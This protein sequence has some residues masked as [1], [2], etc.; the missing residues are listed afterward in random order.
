MPSLTQPP[1]ADTPAS[2]SAPSSATPASPE[3]PGS[4]VRRVAVL[5]N[6]NVGKTSLFNRLCG[7]RHKTSNFPGTTQEARIG[8]PRGAGSGGG[9][10]GGVVLVD[11]PGVYSLELDQPESEVCRAVLAGG[12]APVGERAGVPDAVLVVLDAT[13][14]PRGLVLLGEVIRRRLPVL[15]AVNQADLARRRGLK[16]DLGRLAE[17]LGVPVVACSARTGEG[18]DR[19]AAALSGFRVPTAAVPDG[20]DALAAWADA[21]YAEASEDHDLP[22]STFTDR[23]DR[24]FTHPVLGLLAFA[25]VMAG[26]F[27]AIFK[28]ATYPMDWID[29]LFAALGGWLAGVLPEG[30]LSE[31]LV[32]GAVAGVGATVIFLPQ[33]VLL[34]FLISLLE[35]TG[36]LA[37]AAF[38][39]DRLLRPFGLS[40]HAFVPL[41]S[42]HACA[43]PGIIACRGIPDRRDRLA[44]I[45][46]APFMSCTARIPVYVLLTVLLFPDRPWMQALAFTGCYALGI[47]AGLLSAVVAR[48][49]LLKGRGRALAMELP[50]YRLPNVKNAAL[51]AWDRG[52]I[53]LKKAGTVILAISVVLW[54]LGAFP[55]VD[56]PPEAAGLRDRAALVEAAEPDAAAELA[57][58]ADRLESIHAARSS[59]LGRLGSAVQPVFAPMGADRQLTIGIMASFAAREVFVST[60]AVQVAGS[61]DAEDEG[62]R[63]MLMD[64]RRD[65]GT[66]IFTPAVS[67]ALLVYFVLAMQCLPTLAVTA[68]EAGG[69][70]WAG[71]QLGWM[72]GLA[73]VGAV[74][75]HQAMR[76]GGLG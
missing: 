29:G 64:A 8:T 4:R 31:L 24:A 25:G 63:E 56:P 47:V 23:L 71:I 61:E 54:W 37:R 39:M 13:S 27:F 59:F 42:A 17:R 76:A 60:M 67:W 40:G 1:R 45:L 32:D 46:T 34:F 7:V 28:L 72:F 44:A 48:R 69:W 6:P 62:T 3:P 9:G 43:I 51:V 21:L 20:E 15:V 18:L 41:L 12:T 26:V 30:L 14:M 57:A 38:V 49:T 5:G 74:I 50:A 73:Y 19:L 52:V 66:P 53:F 36:Y 75:V 33:I 58:E 11:L 70:K 16:F 35:D 65:D 55:K 10:G 22:D 2:P 68:R